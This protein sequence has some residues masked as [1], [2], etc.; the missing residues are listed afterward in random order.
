[1]NRRITLCLLLFSASLGLGCGG[2]E[3]ANEGAPAPAEDRS[4]SRVR[5]GLALLSEGHVDAAMEQ[6]HRLAEKEDGAIRPGRAPAWT[7]QLVQRLLRR[8]QLVLA[9]SLLVAAGS[10]EERSPEL[11]YLTANLRVLEGRPDE[12]LTAYRAVEGDPSLM[13]RV[14]HEIATVHLKEGRNEGAIVEARAALALDPDDASL[15]LL[16][17]EAYRRQDRIEDA[18]AQC[19]LVG[20]GSDRWVMEGEIYLNNLDRPD[21]AS[22]LLERALQDTPSIPNVRYLLGR[23]LLASGNALRA[24]KALEPLAVR[25]PPFEES[26]EFLVDAYRALNRRASAD[27]LRSR[28]DREESRARWTELR[29]EGIERSSAGEL[30]AA[31]ESFDAALKIAPESADLHNDRGAVLARMERWEAAEHEFVEAAG[32]DPT[33]PTFQE[34]LARLYHRT[35]DEAAKAIALARW[36]ELAAAADSLAKVDNR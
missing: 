32:L 4:D 1:M 3:T 18:L 14:H 15:H 23:A 33:D 6:F 8:R 28:L 19:R 12:A 25:T 7:P 13:K 27:S 2:S 11:R 22:I 21:T 35:G 31:L 10:L 29:A 20:A 5:M 36:K 17:A 24:R 34:N 16:M 9:D 30:D 26:R